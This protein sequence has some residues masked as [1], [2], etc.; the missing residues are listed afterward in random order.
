MLIEKFR[1]MYQITEPIEA[2]LSIDAAS[3]DRPYQSKFS[4]VFVFHLQPLNP[5]FKCIPLHI[6]PK[7][8]G[9]ANKEIIQI[10]ENICILLKNFGI[11]IK[12]ISTDGDTSYNSKAKETF[13]KYILEFFKYGF[14][15]AIEKVQN[16]EDILW[17]SDFLH[18]L[19][20][21]R[22][23]FIKGPVTIRNIIS[24]V[25]SNETLE[26]DLHLGAPLIDTTNLSFM[27]DYYAIKIFN[28]ENIIKLLKL[29]KNDEILYIL[30]FA[31]WSES[32][33]SPSL[34]KSTRL[35][36]LRISFYIFYYF[37]YQL[38]FS[39]F[40]GGITVY[41]S[42]N[43]KALYFNNE[44]FLIR[45]MNTIVLTYSSMTKYDTICLNRVGNHPLKN[46]FGNVRFICKNYDS[47]ENFVRCAIQT[48]INSLITN[49]FNIIQNVKNRI[50][51]AGV[52]IYPNFGSIE[53]DE[54][55]CSDIDV[56]FNVFINSNIRPFNCDMKKINRDKISYF[57]DFITKL[58]SV[59]SKMPAEIR[60]HKIA[61]GSMI[62]SRCC[63]VY[64]EKILIESE[65]MKNTKLKINEM[66]KGRNLSFAQMEMEEEHSEGQCICHLIQET[67]LPAGLF[68]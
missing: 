45:C 11:I 67:T 8:N 63:G 26:D 47:F 60:H 20:L 61:S 34:K 54:S 55:Q 62:H 23:Q 32:I 2:V 48:Y 49:R 40:E 36:F 57:F 52:S 4:Y 1:E 6:F 19:K 24:H 13:S 33:L 25:F 27:K 17:L 50:N 64:F 22:K 31:L 28:I 30:P 46:F 51:I 56:F 41:K 68:Q 5:A 9:S 7:A 3:L 44:N 38:I 66:E 43:S 65:K 15:S 58:I 16:S 21:A 12:M 29:K 39:V 53:I 59:K 37:Y 10:A 14:E 18:L 35:Y 42:Q